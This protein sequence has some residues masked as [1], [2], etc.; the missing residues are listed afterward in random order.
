MDDNETPHLPP[1]SLW[2][3]GFAMG[4]ACVLTGLVVS[5]PVAVVGAVLAIVFGF[6]WIRDVTTS[7]R[8][9]APGVEPETRA[10]APTAALSAEAAD[11]AEERGRVPAQQLPRRDDARPRR[12]DRRH[13]SPSPSSASP[14]CP[15][16][17]TSDEPDVDLGPL[18]NFPE[19]E[20][21]I[22]TYLED[23]EIGEVRRRTVFVRN[24]GLAESPRARPSFTILFSAASTS[25]A[26][27]SRTAPSTTR[28]R[29][30]SAITS[31]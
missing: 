28:P 13:Q 9:P 21:V 2:P 24:N 22:A 15:R 10:G 8:E 16:S 31:R 4:I 14:S 23:P 25:A 7:V 12:G 1:P 29:R 11:E 18:E 17:R 26:R 6:L 20:F 3:I 30:R 5:F 19:G 27:C